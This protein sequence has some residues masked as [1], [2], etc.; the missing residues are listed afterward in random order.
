MNRAATTAI[1]REQCKELKLP[2]VFAEH[3]AVARQAQDD[4]WPYENFLQEVLDR[5]V[6]KRRANVAQKRLREARFPDTKTLDQLDWNAVR[7]VS[8]TKVQ[9]LSS[10]Q[11]IDD[12]EDVIIIGP[13]GT[14]K[15]H[16]AIALGVEAV[17]RRT[18]VAFLRVADLVRELV[19]ARDDRQLARL[20]RQHRPYRHQGSS[21]QAEDRI[22]RLRRQAQA[23]C[24]VPHPG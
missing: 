16:L 21:V 15:T 4:G 24:E 10:G 6:V 11:F 2:T 17:R 8:R 5:E 13:I 7:G 12:A 1:L 19:E 18:R 23:S 3:P 14:S 9:A 20:H 22:K